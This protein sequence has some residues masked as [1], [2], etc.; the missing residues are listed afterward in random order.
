M[1]RAPMSALEAANP[2]AKCHQQRLEQHIRQS[3]KRPRLDTSPD[4]LKRRRECGSHDV[5]RTASRGIQTNGR[6]SD[7][8][9]APTH[10]PSQSPAPGVPKPEDLSFTEERCHTI[11]T[12]RSLATLSNEALDYLSRKSLSDVLRLRKAHIQQGLDHPS[13]QIIDSFR[14]VRSLFHTLNGSPIH[15]LTHLKLADPI[16]RDVYRKANLAT[17]FSDLYTAHSTLDD[18]QEHF[19]DVFVPMGGRLLK[20]HCRLFLELKTQAFLCDARTDCDSLPNLL[21]QYFSASVRKDL[22]AKRPGTKVLISSEKDFLQ[23]LRNRREMIEQELRSTSL[24]KLST[25][26]ESEALLREAHTCLRKMTEP[27][28]SATP[29]SPAVG[30]EVEASTSLHIP[31]KDEMEAQFSVRGTLDNKTQHSP[32]ACTSSEALPIVESK[33]QEEDFV[34]RAARAA[35]IALGGQISG[36]DSWPPKINSPPPSKVPLPHIQSKPELRPSTETIFQHYDPTA[37]FRTTDCSTPTSS[38]FDTTTVPHPDQSAPTQILYDRARRAA[39]K[40][41]PLPHSAPIQQPQPTIAPNRRTW[42]TEEETAL[43]S[44]L[45]RVRGPHWAKILALYGAGGTS[46]ETLKDRNQVQLKDKARNIK[47]FFL[48]SSTEVPYYLNGVT[49]D[50]RTRAPGLEERLGQG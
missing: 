17:F 37:T 50:L 33:L 19:L 42:S 14:E 36:V 48:K 29:T 7:D 49:G 31:H 11:N 24:Q 13:P 38:D 25:K 20:T 12:L 21:E 18:L 6:P 34:A 16:Q 23:R 45:D 22:L 35:Q 39:T 43:M 2:S 3:T 44:G 4:A 41:N 28:A 1:P 26:Y 46:G 30:G 10:N 5:D 27:P 15:L 8:S 32:Q 9:N 47:L 40:K